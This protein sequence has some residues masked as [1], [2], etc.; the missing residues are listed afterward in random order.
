VGQL[1]TGVDVA[2][3][4]AIIRRVDGF[5]TIKAQADPLPG[6]QAAPLLDR[7]RPA[8]EAIE[9]PPGY[10]LYRDGEYRAS[11]EANEGLA[12][13]APSGSAS[14]RSAEPAPAEFMGTTA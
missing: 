9:R 13:S 2:W 7:L 6:E 8:I 5:P 3:V 12:A 14:T 4:D 1:I 11:A 10:E